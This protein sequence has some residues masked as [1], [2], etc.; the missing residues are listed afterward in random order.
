MV[1]KAATRDAYGKTLVELGGKDK[2]I[3]V[4]DAD[5]SSS[6]RTSW[7]AKEYP[8]RFFNAGIA[9]QDMIG[10]AA[11]LAAS[12]KTAF[13][14]SF[15]MF[16]TGR[17]WE[18]IRNTVAH[19]TLNVK[20]VASH[21]GIT[22]GADGATHQAVEDIA[23][24]RAIKDLPVIVP[25]DAEETKEVI[26]YVAKTKGPFYVRLSRAATPLFYKNGACDFKLGKGS[27]LREGADAAIIA[28]GV[29]VYE[30]DKA[31]AILA[32]EGIAV[33]LINMASISPIDKELIEETAKKTSK[34]VTAEEHSVVGGLGS[35]VAEVLAETFPVKIKMVGVRKSC[36]SGEPDELM[37]YHNIIAED[38]VAAIKSLL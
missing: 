9:E 28:C 18:Q 15:A 5:L 17:C 30:A 25:A 6:T 31:C 11:G 24:M 36:I 37:K 16:A 32:E 33:R 2:N 34:I 22:V 12:G 23:I 8:D 1:E 19:S 14:S 3:V 10:M 20:I 29:M 21:A 38:I 35:A 4:L 27:I 13:A 7:F 26:R